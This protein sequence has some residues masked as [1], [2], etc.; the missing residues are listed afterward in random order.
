MRIKATE[1]LTILLLATSMLLM[2]CSQQKAEWKGTVEEVDGITVVNNP[3]E[4]VYDNDIFFMEEKLNIGEAEGKEEYMFSQIGSIAVDDEERIFVSDW[5]E[6]HI[7]VFDKDGS[8]LMTIGRKGQGPGEFERITALQITNQ[9]ELMIY[10]GNSRRISFFSLEGK[11]IRSQDTSKIQA[12]SF[13]QNSEGNFLAS[14]ATLDPKN[15]LA[16]TELS[17]YDSELD[18]FTHIAESEPQDV[19]TPFLPF[20]VWLLTETDRIIYGNNQT[21]EFYILGPIGNPLRKI[22][23]DYDPV[24]ITEEEKKARLNELEQPEN[25]EVPD[26]HPP[27]RRFT[28]DSEERIFVQTWERPRNNEGYFHDV[29]DSEGRFITKIAFKFPPQIWKMGKFYSIE[30]DED[31]YQMVKRY[32]I[33]WKI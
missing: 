29:F 5:K 16:V 31:G 24:K 11:L 13:R 26:F 1:I 25:K 8:Y 6:S 3:K 22:V 32:K 33:T 21:Y 2:S 4:P 20:T 30:E 17:I 7:K 19:F 10:D 18:K 9:K 27:Y 12:L 28:A 23:R 15:F 14:K